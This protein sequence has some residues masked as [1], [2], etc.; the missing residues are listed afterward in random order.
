MYLLGT[1]TVLQE[2]TLYTEAE[3]TVKDEGDDTGRELT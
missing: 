1:L 2:L 3:W